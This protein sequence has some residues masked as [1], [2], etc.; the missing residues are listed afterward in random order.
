LQLWSYVPSNF[1][2]PPSLIL[3]QRKLQK[4]PGGAHHMGQVSLRAQQ[5][6][7]FRSVCA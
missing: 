7:M 1:L 3:T 4:F 6:S 2:Q 5:A